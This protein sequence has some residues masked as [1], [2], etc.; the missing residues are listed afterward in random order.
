M[1]ILV[2]YIYTHT[3]THTHTHVTPRPLFFCYPLNKWLS[4]AQSSCGRFGNDKYPLPLL[5]FKPLTV[6]SVA[7]LLFRLRTSIKINSKRKSCLHWK[8]TSVTGFEMFKILN[9]FNINCCRYYY[10]HF[11]LYRSWCFELSNMRRRMWWFSMLIDRY[12]RQAVTQ[13]PG[14]A[15]IKGTL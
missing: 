7:Q 1:C 15:T 8:Q 6:Q 4:G 14:T 13:L 2:I 9:M 11:E 3:H 10:Y 12:L 5:G